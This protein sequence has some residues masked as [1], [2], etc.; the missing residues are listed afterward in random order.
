MEKRENVLADKHNNEEN[1]TG[2][3]KRNILVLIAKR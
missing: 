1:G 2:M 3:I